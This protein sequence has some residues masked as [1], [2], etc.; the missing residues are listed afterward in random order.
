MG[1]YLRKR[2]KIMPGLS[3]NVS[4]RGI[5]LSA[6]VRGARVSVGRRGMQVNAGRGALR[7]RATLGGKRKRRAAS[8]KGRYSGGQVQYRKVTAR[9]RSML[10]LAVVVMVVGILLL[11]Y[12]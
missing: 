5:G 8:A 12:R 10:T 3:L 9:S 2:I 7:Y 4:N 11:A 6:G 1:F